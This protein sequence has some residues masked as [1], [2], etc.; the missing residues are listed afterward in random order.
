VIVELLFHEKIYVFGRRWGEVVRI[1]LFTRGADNYIVYICS[2]IQ[3][4]ILDLWKVRIF[5]NFT[6]KIE[7]FDGEVWVVNF[8]GGGAGRLDFTGNLEIKV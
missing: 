4:F 1:P 3:L 6:G 7:V 2:L 5:V 8:S